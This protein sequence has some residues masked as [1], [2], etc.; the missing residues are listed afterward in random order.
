[1]T[2]SAPDRHPGLSESASAVER[3]TRSDS[4]QTAC[5]AGRNR[6]AAIP[7]RLTRARLARDDAS[8]QSAAQMLCDFSTRHTGR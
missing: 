3:S 7:R 8:G 1:M 4:A 5:A 6:F 2:K